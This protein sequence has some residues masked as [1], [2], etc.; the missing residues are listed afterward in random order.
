MAEQQSTPRGWGRIW[1]EGVDRLFLGNR[2]YNYNTGQWDR[3]GVIS[4]GIQQ[5]VN[6]IAGPVGGALY[7]LWANW[8]RRRG[9]DGVPFAN[10]SGN[11]ISN[12]LIG[13]GGGFTGVAPG[14]APTGVAPSTPTGLAGYAAGLGSGATGLPGMVPQQPPGDKLPLDPVTLQPFDRVR[15]T[16]ST[17]PRPSL[18]I[19]TGP[20]ALSHMGGARSAFNHGGTVLEGEAARNWMEAQKYQ[21]DPVNFRYGQGDLMS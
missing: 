21:R 7:G 11:P 19:N 12:H 17:M 3:S 10:V 20:A 9:G 14:G 8:D 15:N 13:S 6:T 16:I 18:A 1:R 5:G 4:G 2:G